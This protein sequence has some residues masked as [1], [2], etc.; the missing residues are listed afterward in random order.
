[1]GVWPFSG[2]NVN[3]GAR[4]QDDVCCCIGGVGNCERRPASE[5]AAAPAPAAVV[6][7]EVQTARE[8]PHEQTISNISTSSNVTSSAGCPT[9][10]C[11]SPE[12]W[13][14]SGCNVNC[15]ARCQ[16]DVCCCIGGVGNCEPRPASAP[17]PAAV[18]AAQIVV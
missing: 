1:M 11:D 16:D 17:A 12:V 10:Q 18:S 13:P 9:C 14:F 8:T 2:C 7:V 6:S 4:C 15:G 5:P 3:C